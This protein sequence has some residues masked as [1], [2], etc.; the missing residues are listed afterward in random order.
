M[1]C[2]TVSR[3]VAIIGVAIV[4]AASHSL[5]GEIRHLTLAEAVHLA[6]TQNRALKIA[7]L[8]VEE[9]QEKKAGDHSS[10]FP[11]ITNQ[12]SALYLTDFYNV[13]IPGGSLGV[14]GGSRIP[15]ENVSVQ[16]GKQTLFSSGTMISQPL[17]QLIRIHQQNRI[18]AAEVA[19]SRDD[20]KKA[21]NEIAVQVHALYYG[22]LV[23]QLQKK[24]AEQQT[25]F[26]NENLRE[27]EEDVH[28]GSKL[29]VVAIGSRAELL[30]CAWTSISEDPDIPWSR[31]CKPFLF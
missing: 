3:T 18:A 19:I 4:A 5:A 21:E 22:I 10:Y 27:N 26:A 20:V 17:T 2:Q 6:V 13:V 1:N 11:S 28:K 29:K 25:E 8:K 31:F 15:P 7:R 12:S 14:A 9:N 16:Q 23:A 24:A 30:S